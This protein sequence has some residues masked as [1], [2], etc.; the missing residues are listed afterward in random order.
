[1]NCGVSRMI[2]LGS[3]QGNLL[4][5]LAKKKER[6]LFA[7]IFPMENLVLAVVELQ[8]RCFRCILRIIGGTLC[9]QL[10]VYNPMCDRSHGLLGQYRHLDCFAGLFV[11]VLV[12]SQLRRELCILSRR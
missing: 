11:H 5:V 7:S 9:I 1:M 2:I 3:S 4:L 12:S 8:S 6:L 10:F